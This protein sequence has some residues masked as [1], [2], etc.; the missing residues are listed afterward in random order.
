MNLEALSLLKKIV[1]S[2]PRDNTRLS[3]HSGIH[4]RYWTLGVSPIVAKK[5]Q[6]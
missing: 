3:G 6:F 2:L 1:V 5:Q 4:Y